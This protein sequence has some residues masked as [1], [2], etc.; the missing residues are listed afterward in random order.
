MADVTTKGNVTV[1]GANGQVAFTGVASA[2]MISMAF[3]DS[4]SSTEQQNSE[5][6]VSGVVASDQR[7]DLS[8]T[9]YPLTA[10]SSDAQYKAITL[11]AILSKVA[12]TQKTAT[13]VSGNVPSQIIRDYHYIGGGRLELQQGG[14]MTMTL[15]L[16]RWAGLTPA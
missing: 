8:L 13:D 3:S 7:Y 2:D 9:F 4:F 10:A 15:P 11:P 1:F 16:R 6:N 5:G 12:V 14:L